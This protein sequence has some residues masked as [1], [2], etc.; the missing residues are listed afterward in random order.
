[1]SIGCELRVREPARVLL[2]GSIAIL[3]RISR[4]A[5]D[6]SDC[7]KSAGQDRF[8]R[9]VSQRDSPTRVSS[10]L[11]S[12]FSIGEIRYFGAVSR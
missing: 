5:Q 12:E 4:V 8:S 7:T 6:T 3:T 11:T 9:F 2:R 1:M 10:K